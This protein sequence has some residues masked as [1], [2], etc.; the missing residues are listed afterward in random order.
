M[1]SIR[2]IIHTIKDRTKSTSKLIENNNNDVGFIISNKK[3]IE[4]WG[5]KPHTAKNILSSLLGGEI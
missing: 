5:F 3:V 4:T 2:Q 1:L